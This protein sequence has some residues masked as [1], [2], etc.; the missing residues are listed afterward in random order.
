MNTDDLIQLFVRE[1]AA[2]PL[3]HPVQQTMLWVGGLL[4][5]LMILLL[6]AGFR[7]DILTRLGVPGFWLELVLLFL[8]GVSASISAFCMSRP[9]GMQWP[10]SRYLPFPLMLLW[11]LVAFVG[12]RGQI[13]INNLWHSMT[14]GQFDCP[15][16]I[17]LFSAV[18][19][20]VIFMLIRMGAAIRYHWAGMMATLSVT[21][22]AYLFMR[23]VENN[24]N[25][26]HLI[27]W[28]ALPI[29]LLCIIGMFAGRYTLRWR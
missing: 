17:L 16:H 15:W 22:F 21:S 28:H 4:V 25:P 13:D 11:A 6:M 27:V 24:D 14:L 19:A 18:P 20:I 10:W 5:Y 26:A 1:G 7:P 3:R 2:R 29:L 9:D 8:L 23:L 12:A